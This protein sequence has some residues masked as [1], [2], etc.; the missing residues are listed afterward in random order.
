M[1]VANEVIKLI[2]A[3]LDVSFN[4][5]PYTRCHETTVLYINRYK[6]VCLCKQGLF[7]ERPIDCRR[8]LT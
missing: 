4:S 3:T 7:P 6:I 8:I 5:G 2:F 1:S